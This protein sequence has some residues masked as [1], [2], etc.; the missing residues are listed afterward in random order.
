MLNLFINQENAISG[1]TTPQSPD[2][3]IYQVGV[4]GGGG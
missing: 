2:P 1:D 3:L 4:G